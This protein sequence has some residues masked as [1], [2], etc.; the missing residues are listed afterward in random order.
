MVKCRR[1]LPVFDLGLCD[2]GLKI[3][4]PERRRFDSI[5]M[6]ICEQF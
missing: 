2:C 4:V 3:H 6:A 5:G 1:E